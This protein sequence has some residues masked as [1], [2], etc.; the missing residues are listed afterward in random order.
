M[1]TLDDAREILQRHWGYED[2]RAPQIPI[3]EAILTGRDVVA[4]LPTGSGK[5]ALYQVPALLNGGLTV[6]ITPLIALM[7]DQVDG[8]VRRKIPAACVHS[9][10]PDEEIPRIYE[11]ARRGKLKLLYLAPERMQ[12]A[13]FMR[14]A[15]S[16]KITTIVIDEAHGI[17]RDGGSHR[18]AY[19]KIP[20]LLAALEDR[21]QVIGV[22]AT[23]TPEV[24]AEILKYGGFE[25]A[26]CVL[27]DPTRP[28]LHYAV[29]DCTAMHPMRALKTLVRSWDLM[30]G[31]HII[32]VATRTAT[33][34]VV[35]ELTNEH[36]N[37]RT[38]DVYSHAIAP[39]LIGIYHAGLM[40]AERTSVQNAF[41][42]GDL[43]VIVA[44][45]AFGMGIDIPDIRNI[46]H[47]GIPESLEAYCQEAGRGG[48]DG[49]P[50]Q[51]VLLDTQQ[52]RDL[53]RFFIDT[54]HPEWE[55]HVRLWD[56][57]NKYSGTIVE[58]AG[59]MAAR[60]GL[61]HDQIV[62]G[63]LA[64]FERNRLVT[65]TA[66][67]PSTAVTFDRKE[68]KA[69]QG[70]NGRRT[71]IVELLLETAEHQDTAWVANVTMDEVKD[72]LGMTGT[73]FRTQL[74]NIGEMVNLWETEN[75]FKGKTTTVV[76][77]CR[78]ADLEQLVVKEQVVAGRVRAMARLA[79]MERYCKIS[80]HAAMI[81]KYFT[82]VE[83]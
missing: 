68:L 63:C 48:R 33:V 39:D 53:R 60:S 41:T 3:M 9:N 12:S 40:A 54:G 66:L 67:P 55:M 6:V 23:A 34:A 44:T 27:N 82:G 5:T 77:R 22:T 25:N 7:K 52:A 36:V 18:P 79:E 61:Q 10:L 57:L 45:N 58:T 31:R 29:V 13:T 76:A 20:Q 75:S 49:L 21:P 16:L 14:L 72:K 32:Y 1:P 62:Y 17:S 43:R 30:G 69:L 80:N 46:I 4:T 50:C 47:I 19:R 70:L 81:R 74:K 71:A 64:T 38:G 15:P 24:L 8:A 51:A 65:R 73:A 28:N 78:G 2:F 11:A 56:Y 26:Q 83:S 59:T 42:S 35:D 37:P